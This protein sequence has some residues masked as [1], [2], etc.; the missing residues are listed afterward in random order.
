MGVSLRN[1]FA[2]H[3]EA[4]LFLTPSA[5]ARRSVTIPIKM[6]ENK[7]TSIC[8]CHGHQSNVITHREQHWEL[9][10]HWEPLRRRKERLHSL[11]WIQWEEKNN[12]VL[13]WYSTK[14]RKLF[15]QLW[16]GSGMGGRYHEPIH[17]TLKMAWEIVWACTWQS[18]WVDLGRLK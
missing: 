7:L 16:E 4:M 15:W 13:S 5:F 18:G 9:S 11:R 10:S 14:S 17:P 6:A 1:G 8:E 2:V 12:I 3:N